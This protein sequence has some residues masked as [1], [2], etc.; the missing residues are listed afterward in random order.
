MTG[1][2]WIVSLQL[3]PEDVPHLDVD[4]LHKRPEPAI[5]R[6]GTESLKVAGHTVNQVVEYH[7]AKHVF[8]DPFSEARM[9]SIRVLQVRFRSHFVLEIDIFGDDEV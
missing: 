7:V 3:R 2:T 4:A 5:G 6:F 8:G 1:G 9:S